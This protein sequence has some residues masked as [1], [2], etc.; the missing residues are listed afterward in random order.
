MNRMQFRAEEYKGQFQE[1]IDELWWK[2]E[3]FA[4]DRTAVHE[5]ERHLFRKM[6][7][8]GYLLLLYFFKLLGTGDQGE[9]VKLEDGRVL[10][11]LEGLHTR[12]YRSVFGGY[13]LH[14]NVYAEREK[15]AQEYVPLDSRLQ[16][17][18][19]SYSYVCQEW[20]QELTVEFSFEQVTEVFSHILG[21]SAGVSA[22][23]R[24]N[25]A[26]AETAEI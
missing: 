13:E 18:E 11:R 24:V 7:R 9:Q 6:L 8:L 21:W 12:R 2:L 26:V 19:S 15:Q 23:E 14:R 4:R 10:R 25:R 1:Y 22:L 3:I 5:V 20:S 16:F 17:P